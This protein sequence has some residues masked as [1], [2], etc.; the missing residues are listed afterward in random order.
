MQYYIHGT[1]L[2]LIGYYLVARTWSQTRPGL[3]EESSGDFVSTVKIHCLL[4]S[5]LV[6]IACATRTPPSKTFTV[7]EGIIDMANRL[8][9]TGMSPR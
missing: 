3:C 4:Y 2:H 7:I 1:F 5:A 8:D 9:A 6:H